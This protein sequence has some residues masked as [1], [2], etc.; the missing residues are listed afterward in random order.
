MKDE[1]ILSKQVF[2]SSLAKRK[3]NFRPGYNIAT[4]H[5]GAS[6]SRALLSS[7]WVFG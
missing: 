4:K 2:H 5:D 3:A 7:E 6:L 1:I